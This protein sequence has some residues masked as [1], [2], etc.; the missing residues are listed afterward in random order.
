MVPDRFAA[1]VVAALDT[2]QAGDVITYGELAALAGHPGAA[3]AAGAV[4]VGTDGLPWWRVVY[5][6][7]RLAPRKGHDQAR[8]LRAEGVTVRD[9]RVVPVDSPG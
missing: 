3:R 5:A 1:R 9:G 2:L 7:G 4:L 8:R 6:D